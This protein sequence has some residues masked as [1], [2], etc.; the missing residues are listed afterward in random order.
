MAKPSPE[1]QMTVELLQSFERE[2]KA[3]LRRCAVTRR[4]VSHF[5]FTRY[6]G[7]FEEVKSFLVLAAFARGKLLNLQM[8]AVERDQLLEHI[9]T[10]W[11]AVSAGPRWK[12]P[13]PSTA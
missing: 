10:G 13:A 1:Q 11:N 9:L 4:Q 8:G 7:F 5:S 2:A 12:S 3:M 6:R